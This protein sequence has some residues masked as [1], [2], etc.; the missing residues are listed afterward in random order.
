M[1]HTN[2]IEAAREIARFCPNTK[3]VILAERTD[4]YG[5]ESLQA[6]V[7]GYL[8]KSDTAAE[9]AQG[10]HLVSKGETYVTRSARDIFQAYR[11]G[12][13]NTQA[14]GLQERRVLRL[15]AEGKR[16]EEIAGILDIS[17]ET[18]RAHR[19]HIMDKLDARDTAG[20]VRYS[21]FSGLLEP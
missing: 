21:I 7:N 19:K 12:I 2:G 15:I 6:G 11:E 20:L 1:P 3:T 4:R 10:I 14:L 8:L 5:L 18:V 13:Q 17:Y 16:T 9:L